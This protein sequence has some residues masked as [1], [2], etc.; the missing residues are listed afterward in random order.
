MTPALM[1]YQQVDKGGNTKNPCYK[2]HAEYPTFSVGA[3]FFPDSAGHIAL[4]P[5]RPE[6]TN[7]IRCLPERLK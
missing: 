4:K 6:G 7:Q 3:N 5:M 1:F 2:N